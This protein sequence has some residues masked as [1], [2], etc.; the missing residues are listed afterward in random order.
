M[1]LAR[2]VF[3]VVDE[4]ELDGVDV[5]FF[6]ELVEGDL[7]ADAAG[8]FAGSSHPGA[9]AEV[10]VDDIVAG[11]E[12]LAVVEECGLAGGAFDPVGHEGGVAGGVV[13]LAGGVCRRRR[14]RA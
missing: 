11:G 9:H 2:I 10:Q 1:A 5:E 4:A 12:R 14:R 3:G 13:L 8:G 6:G 7:E